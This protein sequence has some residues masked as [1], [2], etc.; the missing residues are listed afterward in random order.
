VD[1]LQTYNDIAEAT[2]RA[3]KNTAE[4]IR[5]TDVYKRMGPALGTAKGVGGTLFHGALGPGLM[6][7]DPFASFVKGEATFA[8]AATDFVKDAKQLELGGKVVARSIEEV[9]SKYLQTHDKMLKGTKTFGTYAR[10]FTNTS[11]MMSDTIRDLAG[12]TDL[13]SRS[14]SGL[15]K[16]VKF[17]TGPVATA[18]MAMSVVYS[19]FVS[20]WMDDSTKLEASLVSTR[21]AFKAYQSDLNASFMGAAATNFIRSGGSKQDFLAGMNQ[22]ATYGTIRQES[23]AQAVEIARIVASQT[24]E[25]FQKVLGKSLEN[26]A[27]ISA[28]KTPSQ[29]QA[30]MRQQRLLAGGPYAGVGLGPMNSYQNFSE[31]MGGYFNIMKGQIGSPVREA[32][33]GMPGTGLLDKASAITRLIYQNPAQA[34]LAAIN[35]SYLLGA[36]GAASGL[37]AGASGLTQ[38]MLDNQY[39]TSV[40]MLAEG[41][42]DQ[43]QN[44]GINTPYGAYGRE[45]GRRTEFLGAIKYARQGMGQ[46]DLNIKNSQPELASRQAELERRELILD[47]AKTI[48]AH[49]GGMRGVSAEIVG[50]QNDINVG[51]N[52]GDPTLT[53]K[54]QE[55]LKTL[56]KTTGR[57]IQDVVNSAEIL[58]G[59]YQETKQLLDKPEDLKNFENETKSLKNAVE[60]TAKSINRMVEVRDVIAG[61]SQL[62]T[63]GTA[64]LGLTSMPYETMEKKLRE[65][66]T[67]LIS[68]QETV[69]RLQAITRGGGT[70]T[71]EQEK[72]LRAAQQALKS[73]KFQEYGM[74][75]EDREKLEKLKATNPEQ[76]EKFINELIKGGK[77][78]TTPTQKYKELIQAAYHKFQLTEQEPKMLEMSRKDIMAYTP[79]LQKRGILSG[80]DVKSI[81]TEAGKGE[82]LNLMRA[83]LM[84]QE[85]QAEYERTIGLAKMGAQRNINI[86]SGLL[87]LG[88]ARRDNYGVGDLSNAIKGTDDQRQIAT[89]IL[90]IHKKMFQDELQF[91]IEYTKARM[92][93][94]ETHYNNLNQI[95][96]GKLERYDR[97]YTPQQQFGQ[98]LAG[99]Y[100]TIA[101]AQM[102]R[103]AGEDY[104]REQGRSELDMKLGFAG[105][106]LPRGIQMARQL[107]DFRRARTR[108]RESDQLGISGAENTWGVIGGIPGINM[109]EFEQS[110]GGRNLRLQLLQQNQAAYSRRGIDVSGQITGLARQQQQ[111]AGRKLAVELMMR[112][113]Q[114]KSIQEQVDIMEGGVAGARGG[115]QQDQARI[116]LAEV[117]QK[118]AQHY[119][120]VGD[121]DNAQKYMAKQE[122]VMKLIPEELKKNFGDTQKQ[123]LN[124]LKE[125]SKLLNAINAALGGK[126]QGSGPVPVG[127]AASVSGGSGS[128]AEIISG[129]APDVRGFNKMDREMLSDKYSAFSGRGDLFPGELQELN[130]SGLSLGEIG[131]RT[132]PYR[133]GAE[134]FGPKDAWGETESADFGMSPEQI[135]VW[136]QQQLSGIYDEYNQRESEFSPKE[137]EDAEKLANK[138]T[139]KNKWIDAGYKS[140]DSRFFTDYLDTGIESSPEATGKT[141]T[142]NKS[143]GDK[144]MG[145]AEKFDT[146]VDKLAKVQI[147]ATV[148][149][150]KAEV[151]GAGSY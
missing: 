28:Q 69:S 120:E 93:I 75:D 83:Q 26:L 90:S 107:G 27:V 130:Y 22:A 78:Q 51:F 59:W 129:K 136:N 133:L 135:K 139:E 63:S 134:K 56:A 30:E 29:V 147:R 70:R 84:Q 137:R 37:K 24:G 32:S 58:D 115:R 149:G 97:K 49:P 99:T 80:T 40:Q 110:E 140:A 38:A 124:E 11:K 16:V 145:A 126:P 21:N 112:Q 132:S 65:H 125:H 61:V 81:T 34:L 33:F 6:V 123:S 25:S 36:H 3:L 8:K 128:L 20:K 5:Q 77:L 44:A 12:K 52:I 143:P 55:R 48:A 35:P 122:E 102:G 41:A 116:Q 103:Y 43:E 127:A 57:S 89:Q 101:G 18:V 72:E 15:A 87:E 121:V 2:D 138:V 68:S 45:R 118:A 86:G 144:L 105:M 74:E 47:A 10:D 142:G 150:Q 42:R 79:E 92:Q 114:G 96:R 62:P 54:G 17:S 64:F 88:V 1:I 19:Q 95:E 67:T 66:Q 117:Y 148:N 23:A 31:G 109:G 73:A 60:T 151:S 104:Q 14:F 106:Q 94:I 113:N 53:A 13:L 39:R 146:V 141:S 91:T 82:R 50:A 76:A 7:A 111:F 100:Q 98:T 108:Q 4:L 9:G 119:G 131:A 85:K 71:P 46:L